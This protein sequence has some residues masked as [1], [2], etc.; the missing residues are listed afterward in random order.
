[1]VGRAQPSPPRLA[2]LL[3]FSLSPSHSLFQVFGVDQP[4]DGRILAGLLGF[5]HLAWGGRERGERGAR[6]RNRVETRSAVHTR[7]KHHERG[8]RTTARAFW[9]S[10]HAPTHTQGLPEPRP[11]CN[12]GATRAGESQTSALQRTLSVL[13][14]T[15]LSLFAAAA[16]FFSL[17]PSLASNDL[18]HL[19]EGPPQVRG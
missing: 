13:F 3:P 8:A 17:A 14:P 6:T 10:Q 1:M 18:P 2:T 9:L 12:R 16:C 11:S 4:L 15:A 19:R 5:A 7:E